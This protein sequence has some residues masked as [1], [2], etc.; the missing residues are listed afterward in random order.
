MEHFSLVYALSKAA[1]SGDVKDGKHQVARLKA[2]LEKRGS[3]DNAE[4]LERLV[5]AVNAPVSNKSASFLQSEA[6]PGFDFSGET[7]TSSKHV[8]VDRETSAPMAQVLSIED[9]PRQ[10]PALPSSL[11]GAAEA[12]IREWVHA[13]SLQRLGLEPAKTCLIYG[14]PGT[15]KTQLALWLAG[16]LGLPVILAKLDGLMSSYLGTTSRNIGSLF[17]FANKHRALLLLDE[18]DS[19]AKLRDDPNEVGEIKRVVNTLLQELDRRREHGLT[20]A[21]T[22]HPGLL[23]PAVWRRFE[24]QLE[25][26]MPDVAGRV[27]ILEQYLPPMQLD[28]GQMQ[29]LSWVVEDCSGSEIEDVV[30][31]LKKSV[32]LEPGLTFV[33]RLQRVAAGHGDRLSEPVR[34]LLAGEREELAVQL[35]TTLNLSQARVAE[36]LGVNRSTINRW[37]NEKQTTRGALDGDKTASSVRGKSHSAKEATSR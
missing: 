17:A 28:A 18:F 32:A 19:I 36:A 35:M 21:I 6:R 11:T 26:P 27:R 16:Q 23:D 13:K 12:M 5:S 37:Q 24:A 2:A 34:A 20:I 4:M 33:D 10:M 8:P 31:A 29:L 9:L 3:L 22:N 25:M 7:L 30:K 15:G 14:P 1:L